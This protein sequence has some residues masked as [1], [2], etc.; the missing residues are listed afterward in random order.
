MEPWKTP[1]E[2]CPCC[3]ARIGRLHR[4]RCS[5]EMCPYCGDHAALCECRAPQDDR[6]QWTGLFPG[7]AECQANGWWVKG[8]AKGGW[9]RCGGPDEEGA[10]PDFNRFAVEYRWSRQQKQYVRH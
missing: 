7:E 2:R 10:L 4:R 6:L 1:I 3:Y 9:V 8:D 5:V